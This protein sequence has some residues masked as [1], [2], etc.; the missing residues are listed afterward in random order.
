MKK[1]VVLTVMVLAGA[2]FASSLNVPW[3]VDCYDT[4]P[5]VH[6]YT[7]MGFPPLS[8]VGIAVMGVV[9]LHNNR[10]DDLTCG[11]EYYAKDGTFLAIDGSNTFVIPANST[12]AFRPNADDPDVAHGGQEGVGYIVPNRPKIE[13]LTMWQNVN[14]SIVVRWQG[15]PTDVQGNYREYTAADGGP[16]S[17]LLGFATLLP[18]GAGGG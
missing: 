8:T 6:Q 4:N 17:R 13:G 18:P 16:T 12:M 2:A 3:F 5:A 11:I 15:E 10:S 7:N 14:G 1:L 9:Y